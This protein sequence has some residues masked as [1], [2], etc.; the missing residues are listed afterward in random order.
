MNMANEDQIEELKRIIAEEREAKL[1]IRRAAEA[2]YRARIRT[3]P[4]LKARVWETT[5]RYRNKPENKQKLADIS[6]RSVRKRR[7]RLAGRPKPETCDVCNRGGRIVFDHC[8]ESDKFRGWI[9]H[10][11]NVILGLADDNITFLEKLII[12]LRTAENGQAE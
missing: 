12:Y 6:I 11:C 3:D 4:A 1:V 10:N 7:E 9:C 5:L 2:K 8:H